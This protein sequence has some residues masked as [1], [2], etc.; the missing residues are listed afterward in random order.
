MTAAILTLSLAVLAVLLWVLVCNNRTAKERHAII[1]RVFRQDGSD[2]HDRE[3]AYHRISYERHLF[4]LVLF[5]DPMA[6]Y[7][8]ELRS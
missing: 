8:E 1:R 2:W 7:P 3:I 6:L 5:R 4:A